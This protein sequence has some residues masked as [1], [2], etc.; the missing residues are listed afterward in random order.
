MQYH[1]SGWDVS[2]YSAS[3]HFLMT[4]I[5]TFYPNYLLRKKDYLD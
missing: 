2:A 4:K 3:H 1:L 5:S